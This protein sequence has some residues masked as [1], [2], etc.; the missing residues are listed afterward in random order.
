MVSLQSSLWKVNGAAY[1]LN[2]LKKSLPLSSHTMKAG[3]SSTSIFQMASMPSSGYSST[4]TF[5]M[6]FL[7]ACACVHGAVR[8][9]VS[10]RALACPAGA[11]TSAVLALLRASTSTREV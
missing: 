6:H 3:K 11:G 9:A 7:A 2:S 8:A 4:S 10:E 5:L 1:M